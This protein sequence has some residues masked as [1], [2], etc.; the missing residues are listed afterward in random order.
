MLTKA[1]LHQWKHLYCKCLY[2]SSCNSNT[3][4]TNRRNITLGP[5]TWLW[6]RLSYRRRTLDQ[7]TYARTAILNQFDCFGMRHV[8]GTVT[9][10]LNNLISNLLHIIRNAK[11]QFATRKISGL[12]QMFW[13]KTA[14]TSTRRQNSALLQEYS[15][16]FVL[17][18]FN[19]LERM[20]L[21]ACTFKW[22]AWTNPNCRLDSSWSTGAHVNDRQADSASLA[23]TWA[24]VK[25]LH[26][27]RHRNTSFRDKS[28]PINQ[29]ILHK[30]ST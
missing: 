18:G 27:T 8:L 21:I 20:T 24:W 22:R 28:R 12:D 1:T 19:K 9:I 17:I 30:K 3:K 4:Q 10:D 6:A 16:R 7:Q 26:P 15:S 2:N 11:C 14:M 5:G 25:I 13:M 29:T 23:F